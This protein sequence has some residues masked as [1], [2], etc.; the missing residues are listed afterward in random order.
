MLGAGAFNAVA[1]FALTRAMD[2]LTRGERR[3]EIVSLNEESDYLQG[4][5]AF[6]DDEDFV[7]VPSELREQALL[8]YRALT[9]LQDARKHS[10][11]DLQ[12]PQLSFQLAQA[13]PNL[14]FLSALL[15][16][17]SEA[18]R[19]KELADYLAEYIPRQKTIERMKELAPTNG[20]GSQHPEL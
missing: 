15:R 6:F 13:I 8:Q 1:F 9:A 20:F 12:D 2:I 16:R 19:L 10:E 3:F 11:P 14:D 5:V 7:P 18:Q 4:E 17:R